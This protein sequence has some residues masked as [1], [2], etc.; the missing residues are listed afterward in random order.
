LLVHP[1]IEPWLRRSGDGWH[2]TL[3]ARDEPLASVQ[4]RVA[5]DNEDRW[6]AMQP[7]APECGWQRFAAQL[8]FDGG[9][10]ATR[11]C[12]EVE[13]HGARSWIAA[14]GS[15]D[16]PPRHAARGPRSAITAATCSGFA[17]S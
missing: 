16:H 1:Q 10:V 14:D 6:V 4:L 5:L 13:R 17:P 3:L 7:L 8:P 2:V 15:Y 9:N 11:Y 12:F